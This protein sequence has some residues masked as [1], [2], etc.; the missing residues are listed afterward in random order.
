LLD[1]GTSVLGEVGVDGCTFFGFHT[2][3]FDL[4]GVV[5]DFRAFSFCFHTGFF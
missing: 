5:L 2:I 4:G 3:L 1:D